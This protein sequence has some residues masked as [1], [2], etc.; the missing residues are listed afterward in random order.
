MLKKIFFIIIFS[1][2][3]F[4]IPILSPKALQP[5]FKPDLS[6]LYTAITT[7][8]YNGQ[9]F[10]SSWC[11]NGVVITWD[12]TNSTYNAYCGAWGYFSSEN[13]SSSVLSPLDL[14]SNYLALNKLTQFQTFEYTGSKAPRIWFRYDTINSVWVPQCYYNTCST[15]YTLSSNDFVY[16]F[17]DF[18]PNNNKTKEYLLNKNEY[19]PIFYINYDLSTYVSPLEYWQGS[20]SS[21]FA[22]PDLV[23]GSHN[24][25][26][27]NDL[28]TRPIYLSHQYL[29]Y[30]NY[31]L[32]VD[33]IDSDYALLGST[34]SY[35][36]SS[37]DYYKLG[38]VVTYRKAT[39]TPIL[40]YARTNVG[41][42]S[43]NVTSALAKNDITYQWYVECS[44][45]EFSTDSSIGI[46]DIIVEGAYDTTS[47]FG[48]RPIYDT[49]YLFYTDN[50]IIG[51]SPILRAIT[52]V[53][54][55]PVGPGDDTNVDDVIDSID[56]INNTIT[57]ETLPNTSV[58]SNS[59][60]W[61]PPGPVDSIIN[62]PLSLFN[63]L[64][65]IFSSNDTCQ[66]INVPIPYL[67]NKYLQLPC[68][69]TL[70]SSMGFSVWFEGIG[71]I[72]SA[73]IL[74]HYLIYLYAWVDKPLKLDKI[75][76]TEL[77]I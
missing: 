64:L 39:D 40:V 59:A 23:L 60:G 6:S 52:S 41:T 24:S 8:Q 30:N 42:Y 31:M 65:N 20:Y 13:D 21:Y 37:S 69:N 26:N 35:S 73:Y 28:T 11:Q 15:T 48:P 54:P 32:S 19:S 74:Y 63:G 36:F 70:I 4:L 14:T 66:P 43:C 49:N 38:F 77:V 27:S 76:L 68:F 46:L 57:D 29:G 44:S 3:I 9:N 1:I 51:I 25:F 22:D 17:W 56:N 67:N 58:L 72:A 62:M 2:V 61:L 16:S 75:L 47:I 5:S 34:F 50:G 10:G 45:V 12:N 53:E 7:F 71:A 55:T 33:N 18:Y